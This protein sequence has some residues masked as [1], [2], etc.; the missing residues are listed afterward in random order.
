MKEFR[1]ILEKTSCYT[2]D[3]TVLELVFDKDDTV[4]VRDWFDVIGRATLEKTY[5]KNHSFVVSS[6]RV[7]VIQGSKWFTNAP[8]SY[9]FL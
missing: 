2:Q 4:D 9:T 6:N 8:N 3:K 1:K 5:P 7:A